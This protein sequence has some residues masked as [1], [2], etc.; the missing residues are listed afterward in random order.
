[1]HFKSNT[2]EIAVPNTPDNSTRSSHSD[3][4]KN[5]RGR[6]TVIQE[7]KDDTKL[8]I[9]ATLRDL[10][11]KLETRTTAVSTQTCTY[12][13]AASFG[14]E[15]SYQEGKDDSADIISLQANDS[16]YGSERKAK[17]G[18]KDQFRSG[19]SEKGNHTKMQN[20]FLAF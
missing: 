14:D 7:P 15:L 16:L 6:A 3:M 20:Y 8:Q 9:L 18:D 5:R 10:A 1:M 17:E 4:P 19:A 12:P 11:G 13:L 2:G